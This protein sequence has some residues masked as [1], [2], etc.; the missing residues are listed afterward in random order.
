ATRAVIL[1]GRRVRCGRANIM[2]GLLCPDMFEKGDVLIALTSRL[3]GWCRKRRQIVMDEADAAAEPR[4]A[5]LQG[6]SGGTRPA[7][8][9]LFAA[10]ATA[11]SWRSRFSLCS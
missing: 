8:C 5:R 10:C 2:G 4:R 11:G 3:V 1:S 6:A 9:R 7:R